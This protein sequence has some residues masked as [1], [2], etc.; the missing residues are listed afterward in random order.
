MTDSMHMQTEAMGAMAAAATQEAATQGPRGAAMH[1]LFD[2][3]GMGAPIGLPEPRIDG[4]LKVSGAARYTSDRA[5]PGMLYAVPLGATVARGRIRHLDTATAE[6]MT[7]VRA[8]FTRANIGGFYRV[9]PASHAVLDEKRPP[10]EDDVI[11]YYGQYVA[12]AVAQTLE[13]ATAAAEAIEIAYAS[14]PPD[15]DMHLVGEHPP[16]LDSERG[17]AATAYD[18]APVAS[19]LDHVYTTPI[20]THNPIELHATVACYDDTGFTLYETSQA[21]VNHRAVL[22]QMLGV[23]PEKVRVITEY[24]GS[25][26]G[27]KLWPWGHSLLAAATARQLRVPIKLV[28]TR[29]MMFQTVGHRTNTQQRIRLAA[30]AHGRFL[31]LQHDYLNHTAQGEVR[32]ENCGEVSGYLYSV[33]NV[34]VA[35]SYQSKD[36]APSTSMRGPG[37]VPGL[38]A[39]ESAIDEL[40][41][42]MGIDP[43]ALRLMNEPSFDE[44]RGLPFSSRHLTECLTRGAERFGWARRDPAV[45]SMRRDGLVLGWGMAACAWNARRVAAQASAHLN[46]DGTIR[47]ASATQDI[48]TG[49]Y[50]VVAQMVAGATGLPLARIEVALGDTDLPPGPF[51]GGSVATGSLVPAVFGALQDAT[52]QLLR[53]AC[54]E[55]GPF[56][57]AKKSDLALTGGMVHR[58]SEPS[59]IGQPFERVLERAKLGYIGGSAQAQAS[60]TEPGEPKLS[61]HSFGAQ[62]V[63]VTWQPEIARLRVSRVVTAID[64]GRIINPRTGRNQIEGAVIMGVG[65]ALLEQ[66]HYDARSGAPLNSNLADY[67]MTTHA[68][69]PQIDVIFVEHPDLALNALGARGIGEIGLAGFAPA[70][71]AAVHH[72]T[73]V[74][75]RDLPIKIEDLLS[76]EVVA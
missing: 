68:D 10:L 63:E 42:Q 11:R 57:G 16:M 15:V 51:S 37:A 26:F 52:E 5:L 3:A 59:S 29:Q 20:E 4:A 34:R 14:Q 22:A 6:R 28:V 69:A 71:A 40:A 66:T 25:G 64:G 62:F 7:G 8:I 32:K 58:K 61:T 23:P 55:S 33:P 48:G 12:L 74:R 13:Q 31:S 73:G 21:I 17:D 2:A 39:L 27:G 19:K 65:M 46:A 47:I 18:Q 41:V 43:V 75:V 49:T 50:T 45:G 1:P 38:F 36:I 67:M 24:L 60:G 53:V 56:A 54:G 72:A 70:V 44:S 76:S 35:W 30:D 9:N